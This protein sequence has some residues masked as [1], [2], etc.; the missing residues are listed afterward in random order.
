MDR[1]GGVSSGCG[2]TGVVNRTAQSEASTSKTPPTQPSQPSRSSSQS[3][4]NSAPNKGSVPISIETR[5]ALLW[6]SAKFCA[7]KASSVA[8]TTR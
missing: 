1:C 2:S 6:R 8:N 4:A 3:E 5:V 7:K